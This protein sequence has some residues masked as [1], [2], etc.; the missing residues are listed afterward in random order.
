MKK[1]FLKLTVLVTNLLY[2]VIL[3]SQINCIS[4]P[5][6]AAYLNTGRYPAGPVSFGEG[7]IEVQG[8]AHCGSIRPNFVITA[9][10]ANDPLSILFKS[11]KVV[12]AY[13]FKIP[14]TADLQQVDVFSSKDVLVK[15]LKNYPAL[16]Y[17][18]IKMTKTL[19][20]LNGYTHWGD[21]DHYT[22]KNV[23]YLVVPMTSP[24]PKKAFP[25]WGHP[26]I[27]IFRASDLSFVGY[28]LIPGIKG[29]GQP[30]V[31]W[32]AINKTTG[33]LFTST[34][35]THTI[36]RYQIPWFVLT[37]PHFPGEFGIKYLDNHDLKNGQ[38]KDLT[39]Y[40]LQGGAFD[41]SLLYISNGGAK[42]KGAGQNHAGQP[43]DGL[44]VFET[45]LWT[46]IKHSYNRFYLK[47]GESNCCLPFK[48]PFD[49]SYD[50]GCGI[51]EFHG[52]QPEG[53]D[54]LDLDKYSH[55]KNIDGRLHVL[56][57]SVGVAGNQAW[58]DHYTNIMHVDKRKG[59]TAAWPS[60]KKGLAAFFSDHRF[61]GTKQKP[62]KNVGDAIH[63][64][65]AWENAKISFET[66]Q[67][68]QPSYMTIGGGVVGYMINNVPSTISQG[69]EFPT[70]NLV[71]HN[72]TSKLVLRN[73][74]INFYLSSKPIDPATPKEDYVK[75][76]SVKQMVIIFPWS[77]ASLQVRGLIAAR[78]GTY[79]M[80]TNIDCGVISSPA[81]PVYVKIW[82]SLQGTPLKMALDTEQL[83]KLKAINLPGL[84][85]TLSRKVSIAK[86]IE[87]LQDN[88]I[89]KSPIDG[90]QGG[91]AESLAPMQ[92]PTHY[93]YKHVL[94]IYPNPAYEAI[95]VVFDGKPQTSYSITLN[96]LSGRAVLRKQGRVSM[97]INSITL[98][99]T[100]L[101]K[102]IYVLSMKMTDA[103]QS[104]K[105]LLK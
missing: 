1:Y 98:N 84:I 48:D 24:G 104:I 103:N 61:S 44:H 16:W 65:P 80:G 69:K 9:T 54:I 37:L 93:S 42:C 23:E 57:A 12:D 100:H 94:E 26:A 51:V 6:M 99:V 75:I 49:F 79:Y 36:E 68:P 5:L 2:S 74:I 47:P 17:P 85:D 59:E 32:C 25:S 73:M 56:G 35:D 27:G 33:E 66:P 83:N 15:S 38:N 71:L 4:Q 31:G 91:K 41:G 52:E 30:N 20:M 81:E 18:D 46:E 29:K 105:V 8:L 50:F 58:M 62:F 22:F 40:N 60:T 92:G 97:G 10:K 76:G 101:Q 19:R 64:Y 34:D 95:T 14:I 77:T 86:S 7:R 53:I 88:T 3:S 67:K 21:V 102:G 96:D 90:L 89:A 78:A 72:Y 13:L 82:R 39:L 45:N 43:T 70:A 87:S 63:F 11:F 28:G 55:H